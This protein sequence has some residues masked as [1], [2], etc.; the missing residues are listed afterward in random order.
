VGD[1]DL[2]AV[3]V[4]NKLRATFGSDAVFRSSRS[5]PASTEFDPALRNAVA[6]SVIVLV[7]IGPNWFLAGR[8]VVPRLYD[9]GDWVRTEIELALAGGKRVIPVIVGDADR[10]DAKVLPASI[11]KLAGLQYVRLHHRPAEYDL[12]HLADEVQR[13]LPPDVGGTRMPRAT[14]PAR[15]TD[16]GP[17]HPAADVR[18]G[19][20]DVGGRHYGDSIVHRC[21]DFANA[22]RGEISFNLGK[23]Y[24]RFASTVGVLDGAREAGQTG[25]FR[26]VLD[27][28]V[29]EE[30]GVRQGDP[31]L[32][33]VD[34]TD[35]LNL[36]LITYRPGMTVNPMMAGARIAG[37]LSNNLPELAWGNPTV[38]P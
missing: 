1:T 2:A 32:V 7:L 36:T 14:A 18:L 9:A 31:R 35:G 8:N 38:H 30:V 23:R 10:P 24:R 27:G 37:G 16:L 19:P 13:N 33:E 6:D 25:V 15:L 22:P 26:V 29:K 3:L 17:I 5:M 20:A 4:D 28:M 11:E 34:V 12:M 21:N